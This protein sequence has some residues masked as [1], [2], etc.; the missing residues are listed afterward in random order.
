MSFLEILESLP[1]W[2]KITGVS[3][4]IGL[5]VLSI[6]LIYISYQ[7]GGEEVVNLPSNLS[8]IKENVTEI[9]KETAIETST[10]VGGQIINEFS[11]SGKEL[12]KDVKD[13]VAKR[14]IESSWTLA[15]LCL[16]ALVILIIC[17]AFWK[18]IQ[19]LGKAIPI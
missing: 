13:P 11:E 1:G 15:G 14:S 2:A 16:A 18:I 7:P 6:F 3:T 17:S 9:L 4:L 10:T 8:D 19:A 5:V 12:A